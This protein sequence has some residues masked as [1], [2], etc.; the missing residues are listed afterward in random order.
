[1][2]NRTVSNLNIRDIALRD[3]F[4]LAE[5][6]NFAVIY[7]I[8]ILTTWIP[9]T[10]SAMLLGFIFILCLASL[11]NL[12]V[13]E[14]VHPFLID[15][16]WLKSGLLI[17]G[18]LVILIIYLVTGN[19]SGLDHVSNAGTDYLS[20][21][22]GY[23]ILGTN[24]LRNTRW[25]QFT[26]LFTLFALCTHLFIIPKSLY[27]INKLLGWCC[28]NV[29]IMAFIGFLYKASA[30]KAPLFIEGYGF[31][32]FFFYF[33]YDG[34]WAAFAMVWVFVS[35]AL[36]VIEFEKES[37]PFIKTSAPIYI[38]ISILLASTALIVEANLP[39]AFLALS[40]S[41]ICIQKIKFFSSKKDP[42]FKSLKPYCILLFITSFLFGI[43][44]LILSYPGSDEI[45]HLKNS[46]LE[47]FYKSPIFGWGIDA[48]QLLAPFYNDVHLLGDYHEIAPTGILSMLLEFGILG[49]LIITLYTGFLL[50]RYSI[51]KQ[52][53]PFSN[54]LLM[55]LFALLMLNFFETPFYSIPILYSYWILWFCA[56]RWADLLIKN[57]DEVDNSLQLVTDD[58]LRNVPFVKE[59]KKDV[60][61]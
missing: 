21:K 56:F 19:S 59:P 30:L 12:R 10:R 33:A 58:K 9:F 34:F 48:F 6:L 60:F 4:T 37:T 1:M 52:E 57:P 11:L 28:I 36:S 5:K 8:F 17:S 25:G 42:I 50:I 20:L 38:T 15:K 45:M 39:A 53:N 47:I 40:Y 35:Y 41:F 23:N 46:A 43:Y 44:R 55:G 13:H 3:N 49:T 18:P 26:A 54:T 61:K 32:D 27:F 31:D 29:G 24:L 14:K 51:L 7:L 2:E 16:L 22:E